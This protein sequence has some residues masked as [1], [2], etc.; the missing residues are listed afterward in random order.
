LEAL[1]YSGQELDET[2]ESVDNQSLFPQGWKADASGV[3]AA[4]CC[5]SLAGD[6]AGLIAAQERDA[7]GDFGFGSV[8]VKGDGVVV[9]VDDVLGMH[10]HGEL[11]FD[12]TG[13]DAVGANAVLAQLCGLLFGEMDDGGF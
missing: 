13:A 7:G 9:C 8:A 6:V 10:G 3:K 1:A 5:E 11:G 12:R 2:L 4:I